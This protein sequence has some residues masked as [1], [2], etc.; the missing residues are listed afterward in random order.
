MQGLL[1]GLNSFFDKMGRDMK[2]GNEEGES[3]TKEI[4]V[5]DDDEAVSEVIAEILSI[6]KRFK[7]MRFYSKRIE[8]L[9]LQLFDDRW[10]LVVLDNVLDR[11]L[12]IELLQRMRK[13]GVYTPVIM[14]SANMDM[15]HREIAISNGARH[16]EKPQDLEVLLRVSAEMTGTRHPV[17]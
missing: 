15:R 17:Y 12:G 8:L 2:H 5:V 16:M 13:E 4:L 6:N 9:E 7:V 10:D 3:G 11:I 14:L 1:V